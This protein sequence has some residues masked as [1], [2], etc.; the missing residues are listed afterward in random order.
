MQQ[1]SLPNRAATSLA[2][3]MLLNLCAC[4]A[5][6]EPPPTNFFVVGT[7]EFAA[8]GTTP[9]AV[10]GVQM[11]FLADEASSGG[12]DLNGD[13]GLGVDQVAIAVNVDTKV[14]TNLGV[15][16]LSALWLGN[17]LYLVVDEALD[18]FDHG[19]QAG[20][21]DLVL[22][23][24][25]AG[26]P[27]PV[28]IDS[29]DRTSPHPMLAVENTLFYASDE[30]PAAATESSIYAIDGSFPQ[31]PRPVFTRDNVV[32]LRPKLLGA[33]DGL[34]F[35]ALDETLEGVVLNG[36]AAADDT[37]VL[38]LLDGT[39]SMQPG[40]YTLLV[41]N[42]ELAMASGSAPFAAKSQSA[43]DWLAGFLVDESSE[44]VNLNL[45]DGTTLPINWQI[46]AC[47]AADS[48]QTDQV[49]HV[50][51]FAAWD[52]NPAGQAPINTG[53]AGS[54]QVLIAGDAVG[55]VCLEADENDC[56]F[57]GD[58]DFADSIL[59]WIRIDI[60]TAPYS[61]AGPVRASD[62]LL[63]LDLSV[64]G[65]AQGIAVLDGDFVIQ[66]DEQAD[67]RSHDD[68]A[69]A[70][71]EL[72]GWVD[73]QAAIPAWTFNHSASGSSYT[74]ATWMGA[75]P[76]PDILGIAFAESSNA[77]DLNNDGDLLDSM[78]TWPALTGTPRAL[79][80]LGK[81]LAADQDNAGITHSNGYGFFRFS[82]AENGNA[83]SNG[84]GNAT[85]VL[86]VRV[87]F[88]NGL[89]SNMGILN[90]LPRG[91]L[92]TEGDGVSP[93]AAYLF[94]ETFLGID[95]NNDGDSADLVP[96]YFRLP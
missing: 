86:L 25:R 16:A 91:S 96:R 60:A 37:H 20:T 83:D 5:G 11:V 23:H 2:L 74:T 22:M 41:R 62:L 13:G 48:D 61:T 79:T 6:D 87:S 58:S 50:I 54:Q 14:E 82:E 85:D 38:A 28:F 59:R 68:D 94:D 76:D 26:L 52:A 21:T 15:A 30:V 18:G 55:T 40:G 78:P 90:E 27:S 10:S 45:F 24:W 17:H 32:P 72:V 29:L 1:L 75:Q 63:A 34:V 46:A 12:R 9:L 19:G 49:L 81:F 65:P 64:P 80:F 8:T 57:N 66:C 67:G 56:I 44:G 89:A 4:S 70:N 3:G 95:L 73:P 88:E 35:L 84:N 43:H 31:T 92:A 51:R 33:R 47:G 77:E 71:R 36:D 7:S 53:L 39:G 69:A 42:T 93:G